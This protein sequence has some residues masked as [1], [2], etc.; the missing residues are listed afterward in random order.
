MAYI[1]KIGN[2]GSKKFKTLASA[3]GYAKLKQMK[4]VFIAKPTP[5]GF[6]IFR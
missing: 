2:S 1:L 4:K 3:R 5:K 6:Q